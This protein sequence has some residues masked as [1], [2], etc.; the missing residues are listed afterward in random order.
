MNKHL[1]FIFAVWDSFFD[2]YYLSA[3]AAISVLAEGG[4]IGPSRYRT[5]W[6]ADL[7]SE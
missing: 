3:K 1:D 5:R 2:H 6:A 7:S 4:S